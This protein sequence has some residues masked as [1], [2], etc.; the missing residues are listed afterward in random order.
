M[1]WD[2][3]SVSPQTASS[4][5]T[6]CSVRC[7][8]GPLVETIP[9]DAGAFAYGFIGTEG[10]ENWFKFLTGTAGDYAIQTYGSTDTYM[11][12][13]DSDQTTIIAEDNDGANLEIQRLCRT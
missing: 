1:G 4:L 9:G 13:Y 8:K 11:Y 10:E 3:T 6:G 7:L 5:T 12:L 2:N